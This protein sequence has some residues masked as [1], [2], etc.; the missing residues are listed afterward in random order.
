MSTCSLRVDCAGGE[1]HVNPILAA[2]Y[3]E[4]SFGKKT[5]LRTAGLWATPGRITAV[6]GRNGCG[7]TTLIRITCGM[8][9]PDSGVVIYDKERYSRPR[10]WRLA[11]RG[12]FFLPERDLLMQNLTCGEHM[13]VLAYHH[14]ESHIDEAVDRLRIR[15]LLDRRPRQ[16]SG[17][18][19]RRVELAIALARQP[20]CLIAD[21]PFYGI[22]PKDA[23]LLQQVFRELADAGT[24]IIVT[25]HE[26]RYLLDIA[27][28]VIWHTAGT[29]HALGDAQTAREHHQF[30]QE[31]L[32]GKLPD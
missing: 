1:P 20:R 23:E 18:E 25:G 11:R 19:V 28:D 8:L 10:L 31:Y 26:V 12:L 3:I 4:K 24:A 21:E 7:K 27:D 6:L 32:D 14:V 5:V 13:R 17:G 16:V 2:E 9:R 30:R 29:T 22:A 15:D